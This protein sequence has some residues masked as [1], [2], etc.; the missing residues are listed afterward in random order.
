MVAYSNS[1]SSSTISQYHSEFGMANALFWRNAKTKL[2][3]EK[4]HGHKD[5]N[6][7]Q[8]LPTNGI[9]LGIRIRATLAGRARVLS[10]HP[11]LVECHLVYTVH[12]RFIKA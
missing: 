10:S 9:T 6:Q 3:A 8:T 4:T 5:E 12:F 7:Q 11:Y 2:F 1:S